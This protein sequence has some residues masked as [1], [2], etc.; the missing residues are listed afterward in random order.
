MLA[1]LVLI[2]A[3]ILAFSGFGASQ[4]TCRKTL[5]EAPAIFGLKLGMTFDQMQA[6]LGT[7]FKF[8]PKKTG[9][10]SYFQ[11][12]IDR[13]SPPNLPGIRAIYLRFFDHKLYQIEIFYE[14]KG[15]EIGL[16]DLLARLSSDAGIAAS[17]WSVNGRK[18]EINCGEF[19]IQADVPLNPRLQITDPAAE[20]EFT[21]KLKEQKQSKKKGS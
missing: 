9:E 21:K 5:Q 8:K 17:D 14:D 3:L 6:V 15:K 2:S 1:K 19:V 13:P 11:N 12:F 7:A 16:A 10:G 18:A 4:E 20:A